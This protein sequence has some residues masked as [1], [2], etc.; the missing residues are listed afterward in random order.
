MENNILKYGLIGERL[1]HS[2]SKEIH[3]KFAPYT[4]DICEIPRDVLREFMKKAEF[5]GINVTI[6]YKEAVIPYLHE[7]S[8]TARS[9]GAVNTVVN[10]NGRLCGH[11]TDFFGL[12]ALIK[13]MGLS[14]ERKKVAILGTGGTS[15]TATAVARSQG[16]LGICLVSRSGK[17]DAIT[18]DEL[19]EYYSDAEIIINTTPSGMYPSWNS[20]PIDLSRLSSLEGVVDVVYNP[21]NTRLVQEAR[22]RGIK[23]ECGLYMLVAQA[24]RASE[25]FLDTKYP[26]TLIDEIYND[27][28]RPKRNIVL[29]GMP[30][31]GKT[32]VGRLLSSMLDMQV[33]DSDAE[34]E[35][36]EGRSISEIFNTEGEEYFRR[37]EAE[38]ISELG[39]K[40]HI[41]ISTG[42]GA[43]LRSETIMAMK[44][45]GRVYFI[46]RP[47]SELLPTP[48]RPL[49]LTADAIKKRYE[50]RYGIYVSTADVLVISDGTAEETATKIFEDFKK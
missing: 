47:L 11:N 24:V 12:S 13:K 1:T 25:L 27:I 3:E 18:Y 19:Y 35:R 50:E 43:I 44:Q 40:N 15:K 32:T 20:T 37:L 5:S 16:A 38:V 8:S 2:F 30:G 45:N 41:I 7:I 14:L 9:I 21:L 22:S 23:A 10:K 4:Y 42:G 46:D 39:S 17:G 48:D 49:A 26:E 33:V 36:R 34:I 6:P 28:I 29:T 31:S